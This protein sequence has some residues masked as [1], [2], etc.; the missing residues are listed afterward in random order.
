LIFKSQPGAKRLQPLQ[1]LPEP[2]AA[3]CAPPEAEPPHAHAHALPPPV[4]TMV[5][6]NY[7]VILGSHRNSCLKIEKNGVTQ[8]MVRGVAVASVSP[9]EFRPYWVQISDG[10]GS[11]AVGTGTDPSLHSL[12]YR[13]LDQDPSGPIPN[14]RFVGLSCWDRHACY[15]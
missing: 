7:T 9:R 8:A 11:I 6:P 15:R 4:M 13:W 3:G 12:A 1:R 10:G 5:E 14:V 2:L